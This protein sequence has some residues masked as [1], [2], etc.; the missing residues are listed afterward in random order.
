[1]NTIHPSTTF[2]L[3]KVEEAHRLAKLEQRRMFLDAPAAQADQAPTTM[4]VRAQQR[5]GVAMATVV[6]LLV[7][8]AGAAFAGEADP[9]RQSTGGGG[10][11]CGGVHI[12]PAPC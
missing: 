9:Q 6:M 2:H 11:G 12:V 7:L 1:M 3:A 8:A 10:G 5:L 4:R